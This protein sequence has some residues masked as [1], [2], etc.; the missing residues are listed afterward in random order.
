MDEPHIS[1]ARTVSSGCTG[2]WGVLPAYATM[3]TARSASSTPRHR[4]GVI[5]SPNMRVPM[6]TPNT[7]M[8]DEIITCVLLNSSP[9]ERMEYQNVNER[10]FRAK[11]AATNIRGDTFV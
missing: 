3:E 11:A 10:V 8:L 9:D 4:R 7:I 2:T 1:V 5:T 6:D